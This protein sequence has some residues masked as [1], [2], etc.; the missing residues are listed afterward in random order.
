MLF[1]GILFC[2]S[3]SC[4]FALLCYYTTFLAPLDGLSVFGWRVL[5]TVILI[6]TL[7]TM[8]REWRKLAQSL[9]TLARHPGKFLPLF[10]CAGLMSMQVGLFGWAPLHGESQALALG[11]FLMPLMMV[12]CGRLFFAEKLSRWQRCAVILAAIGV[13]AQVMLHGELSWV[14]LLVMLGYPPYFI[15][16]RYLGL[17]AIHSMLIEHLCMLPLA[18]AFLWVEQ[19]NPAFFDLHGKAGWGILIGLGLLGGSALLSYL[20]GNQRLPLSL[21]GMLG[22]VEPLLLF[23]VALVLPDGHFTPIDL[24]TYLPIWAA[25]CCLLRQGWLSFKEQQIALQAAKTAI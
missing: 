1:S 17:K 16:K 10:L 25:I 11:Y 2:L 20:A 7:I 22:Y 14:S 21:F 19:G 18:I 6:A 8:L 23:V 12:I 15:I 5:G 24:A 4:L 3:A 9:T 13:S